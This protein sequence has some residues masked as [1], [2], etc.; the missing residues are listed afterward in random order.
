M[1]LNAEE[2]IALLNAVDPEYRPG[3]KEAVTWGLLMIRDYLAMDGDGALWLTE[4]G[5]A[6]LALWVES[7]GGAEA[8]IKHLAEFAGRR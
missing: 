8:L 7:K 3:F 2:M 6:E 4:K 5:A 1:G